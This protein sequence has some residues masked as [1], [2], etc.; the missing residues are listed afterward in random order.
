MKEVVDS[1]FF[2]EHFFSEETETKRKTSRKLRELVRSKK[3]ILPTLVISEVVQ[4]MCE[5]VGREEANLCYLSL[6][7]SGLK[8]RDLDQEIAKEAG[9]LKCRYRG[10]PMGDCIVAATAIITQAKVLSDDP[11]FKAMKEIKCTWI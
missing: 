4:F 9:V 10:V 6:I 8:V 5:K 11:H 1:R 7:R 2:A 3:G